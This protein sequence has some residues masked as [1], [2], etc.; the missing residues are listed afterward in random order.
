MSR[1]EDTI[2][3][4]THLQELERRIGGKR[5]LSNSDGKM[6]W[7]KL[8]VYFFFESGERRS[9][10]GVGPRVVRVGTH[11]LTA[12]SRTTLWNRLRQH[13]GTLHPYGGNHRGSIFRLLVGEALIRRGVVDSKDSWGRGSNAPPAVRES[14]HPIEARV[15]HY[16]GAM[17]FLFVPILD[18][19]GTDSKRGYIERNAIA[20]LSNYASDAADPPSS[21]WLGLRSARERVCRSGLW[22]NNPVD[23]DYLPE[24]LDVFAE[25]IADVK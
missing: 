8:G 2:V 15:S 12:K 16:I 9:G 1:I 17:P 4:Y 3:F 21:E 6:G 20:L 13:R 5:S 11:A 7:P 22:N 25:L 24:F 19:P 18:A 14:E 10:S 23:E